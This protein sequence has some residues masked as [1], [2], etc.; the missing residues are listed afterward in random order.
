[1]MHVVALSQGLVYAGA[2]LLPPRPFYATGQEIE[3]W[4][5]W[6]GGQ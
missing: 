1:V 6:Q 2:S 5:P 4:R 3:H